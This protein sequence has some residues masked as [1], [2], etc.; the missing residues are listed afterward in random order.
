ME[1]GIRWE[2]VLRVLY[3]QHCVCFKLIEKVSIAHLDVDGGVVVPN[4]M[5]LD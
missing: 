5:D 2:N 4:H 1:Y 3:G